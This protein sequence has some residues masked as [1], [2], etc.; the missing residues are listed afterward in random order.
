VPPL[1]GSRDALSPEEHVR[2]GTS[3]E[4]QGLRAQAVGQYEA[5]VRRDPACA[6]GW[7]AMGNIA[8]TDGRLKEAET[9]FRKA[10]K[11]SPHHPG[12]GNNLAMVIL[13]RNGN[14]PEAE[15]LAQDALRQ[16]GALRPYILDTLANI[17]L[18]ERRYAD[19][20]AAIDQAEAATP[21]D[22]RL[23]R[24]QLLATRNNIKAAAAAHEQAPAE[25]QR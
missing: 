11:A 10:L 13:A 18:R 21:P 24:D 9:S 20:A 23:V 7:L 5:A 8:F 16:A 6:E 4:A 25:L 17:Y 12:A 1:I 3:Y 15:A 19:A 2:L 22:S 14:L